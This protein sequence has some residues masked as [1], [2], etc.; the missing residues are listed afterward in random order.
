MSLP[1]KELIR[2]GQ[3]QL[4]QAGIADADRDAK[5]LY[6]YLDRLDAVGLMMHWQNVLQDNTCEAYF[7]LI[8]RRASGEPMQYITGQQG[9]MGFSFKVTPAV[10]IPRQDTETMTEDA[11]EIIKKGSLRGEKY[12]EKAIK[13]VLDL[14]CGS[15]A[16]GLSIAKLCPGIKMTCSDISGEAVKIAE[17]NAASLNLKSVRFEVGDLFAPFCG[18]LGKKKFDLIISNPPYINTGVIATL[19]K[20]V[21][22][23]EPLSALDGG[24]DGLTFYRR[25]ADEAPLHMNKNGI[26]MMEIGYDQRQAVMQLMTEAEKFCDIICLKDLAG[27]DRIIAAR[28]KGKKD[29]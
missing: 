7:Q 17:E 18:K 10:L 1:L 15:G 26:L 5:D 2:I 13:D 4:R 21:R 25:I 16:I 8:E 12:T 27:K 23:H 11:V 29:K 14:C 24:P 20:E 3:N 9:F 28:L 6:C 22:D 19:Q